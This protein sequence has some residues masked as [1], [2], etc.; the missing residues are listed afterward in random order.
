M[1]RDELAAL[2]SLVSPLIRKGQPLAHI[3]AHHAEEIPCGERTLYKY[4]SAG[5]LTA[6][7]LDMRRTVRYRKRVRSVPTP[8]I[9]YR[10]KEGHHYSDYLDFIA[11]ALGNKGKTSREVIRNYFLTDFIKDHIKTYQKRPIYWLFDSGKQNGFK[12][13]V[14]MHRWNADTI[15]NVRV[16]YL[17]RIQ[18]VYEKEITRMQEIIDNSHD[19]KEISNATKRKEK[20]QKQIKETKDYD[21]KIAHLALSRIDIDLDDGVKVNYEKV[22]TVDGKKMQ[23]LTKI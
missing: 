17:H 15:G 14:Y 12:A 16:E 19:N 5:Y 1:T 11:N 13:L 20:L 6:R 4:I 3:L 23:I 22:Q 9:S 21:A 8:K 18:R 7:N 10:K 2:D